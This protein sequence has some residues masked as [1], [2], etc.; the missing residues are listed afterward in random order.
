MFTVAAVS[1]GLAFAAA[2]FVLSDMMLFWWDT[3]HGPSPTIESVRRRAQWGRPRI[4]E[5]TPGGIRLRRFLNEPHHDSI[6]N[7]DTVIRTNALGYR[8]SSIGPKPQGEYRILV[9]GDSITLGA[10]LDEDETFPAQIE[11]RLTTTQK[12]VRVINAA[13]A[14]L[15]LNEELQILIETGLLVQPDVV[16]VGLYLNDASDL[17]FYPIRQGWLAKSPIAMRIANLQQARE[18]SGRSHERY[19]RLSGKPF[20]STYP[21]DAWRTNRDAFETEIAKACVD[22]G[23][24]WFQ[25][26]WDQMKVDLETM[27][28]LGEEYGFEL[29]VILLPVI[30]QVEAVFLE[31]RPQRMFER[32]MNDLNVRHLDLL[33]VLRAAYQSLNRSLAYDH[34]H[35]TPEGNHIVAEALAEFLSK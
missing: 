28:I 8:S 9:L 14:D 31:D 25:R 17:P 10:Y 32:M 5:G 23:N 33:P 21:E 16:L 35:L 3:T 22:W 34:C 19:E 24:A 26:P 30:F 11:A 12:P 15:T 18:L 6:S 1:L 20:P 27:R 7:R 29:I 2:I 4:Y 13:V